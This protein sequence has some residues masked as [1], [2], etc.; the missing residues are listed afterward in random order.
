MPE[1]RTDRK[2]PAGKMCHGKLASEVSSRERTNVGAGDGDQV[3][4]DRLW[5]QPKFNTFENEPL[6]FTPHDVEHMTHTLYIY[7]NGFML[8]NPF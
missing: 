1:V 5:V 4:T 6:W 7:I 8:R 2:S 3:M